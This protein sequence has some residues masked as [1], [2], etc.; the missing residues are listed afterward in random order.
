MMA[1]TLEFHRK[2]I[3]LDGVADM[4]DEDY[5]DLVRF[6]KQYN[7]NHETEVLAQIMAARGDE[8]AMA[9]VREADPEGAQAADVNEYS[10]WTVEELKEELSVRELA[11]SGNKAELVQRLADSDA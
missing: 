11:V 4:S 10:S 7:D 1:N 3:D 5:D 9:E 8:E 2:E 6:I